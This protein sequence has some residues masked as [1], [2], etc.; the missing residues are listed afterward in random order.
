MNEFP[1]LSRDRRSKDVLS[2]FGGYNAKL[3][4]VEG[5]FS[6]MENMTSRYYPILSVRDRRAIRGEGYTNMQ[7]LL[8]K[9][10]LIYVA[11]NKLYI[12]FTEIALPSGYAITD[13]N[14]TIETMGS[15][16]LIFPDKL[17]YDRESQTWTHMNAYA[18]GSRQNIFLLYD[19]N[20][21]VNAQPS[22][23]YDTHTPTNGAYKYDRKLDGLGNYL[24]SVYYKYS[25]QNSS[26]I[27][28]NNLR[29]RMWFDGVVLSPLGFKDGD[30]VKITVDPSALSENVGKTMF[31]YED[32]NRRYAYV[33]IELTN[34]IGTFPFLTFPNV[35]I[36]MFTTAASSVM[37]V[38]REVPTLDYITEYNN[39]L[40]GVEHDGHEIW[41]CKLGDPC[42]WNSF[43]GISTDSWR[44]T[45]GSDG[46]FTGAITYNGYPTIFKEHSL[47]KI[48]VSS[49][50]AHQYKEVFLDGVQRQSAESIREIGGVLYYKGVTGIYAYNGGVPVCISEKLSQNDLDF[51]SA[52][53]IDDVYYI[54]MNGHEFA[55]D[56]K[57]G[58]WTKRTTETYL[59]AKYKDTLIA[60][61]NGN[62]YSV[63]K[64]DNPFTSYTEENMNEVEWYVV[65]GK[66][67]YSDVKSY[68][69]RLSI[70]FMLD[71]TQS[72]FGYP[73]NEASISLSIEYDSSGIWE[74]IF[75]IS[76][77]GSRTFTMPVRP[78]RCDHLRY[79]IEGRGMVKILSVMKTMVGGSDI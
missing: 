26:W 1:M 40:W 77:I 27:P 7:G 76:D 25:D 60:F 56:T 71:K 21:Q 14:K 55:Y 63:G 54:T 69:L 66:I 35:T 79:R 24:P 16:V 68:L 73:N 9:E 48:A 17:M 22:E 8:G 59:Y 52:G 62:F 49:T 41:A 75:S 74:H 34:D 10:A 46:E 57:T 70:R 37:E 38:E 47:I 33:K 36:P 15:R 32:G 5:E 13:G 44:A 23:Y 11:D 72:D 65:S 42:N 58:I 20:T 78:H 51:G 61:G 53:D 67:S 3:D 31:P 2:A 39:R 29:Y 30:Y 4:C 6:D 45:V 12:N 64:H 28:C 19:G 43:E 50:G 18:M